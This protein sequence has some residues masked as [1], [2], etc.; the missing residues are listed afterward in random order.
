[1]EKLRI[2]TKKQEKI[3]NNLFDILGLTVEDLIN[4]KNYKERIEKLEKEREISNKRLEIL[5]KGYKA[6]NEATTYLLS[7]K[8]N[9]EIKDTLDWS[10]E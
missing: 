3:L 7:K 10:E 2:I 1:M 8:A 9:E 4:I 6:C 5:E